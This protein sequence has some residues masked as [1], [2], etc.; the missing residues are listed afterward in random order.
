LSLMS[1]GTA[2]GFAG[3]HTHCLPRLGVVFVFIWHCLPSAELFSLLPRLQ[4]CFG[5]KFFQPTQAKLEAISIIV[6][7]I[8]KAIHSYKRRRWGG[9]SGYGLLFKVSR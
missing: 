2:F 4:Q 3:A 7:E 6:E 8:V 5:L 9:V 1:F